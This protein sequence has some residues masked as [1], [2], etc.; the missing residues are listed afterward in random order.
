MKTMK[1]L[2]F[3]GAG[4]SNTGG[5]D[6]TNCRLRTRIK[7]KAGRVIYLEI[8]GHETHKYSP[9]FMKHYTIGGSVTHCFYDDRAEDARKNYSPELYKLERFNYEY[10]QENILKFV[11]DK[12]M[13]DFNNMRISD[14]IRVHDTEK[15]LC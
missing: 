6:V 8:G 5:N 14:T 1:T 9:T 12:L 15:P 3:E 11:N 7:N 10:T 2:V 4:C 13:G